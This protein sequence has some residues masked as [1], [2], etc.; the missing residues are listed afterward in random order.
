MNNEKTRAG[1]KK[2]AGIIL[3]VFT[4]AL[5]AAGAVIILRYTINKAFLMDYSMERY[6]ET[7]ESLLIYVETGENYVAPYNV[8]NVKY[9]N[10]DYENAAQYFY[11]AL[12]KEHPEEKDCLIRINL[13]LS[14][15]R[16][17]PFETMDRQD[18]DEVAE[19][20]DVLRT[21]RQ[22]LTENGCADEASD[23]FNG[24]SKDAEKLKRDID[25][26]IRELMKQP[27]SSENCPD[28]SEGQSNEGTRSNDQSDDPQNNESGGDIRE[29]PADVEEEQQRSLE[30]QLKEQKKDLNEE[31]YNSEQSQ[32]KYIEGSGEMSGYGEGAPW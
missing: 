29:E 17:Y 1:L 3:K 24:H 32:F 16:S 7:P 10:G 5:I 9:L 4:Y 12:G 20:L 21:A 31:N 14:L 25:D 18:P 30:Q 19:A 27:S 15:L 8:G 28:P 26:M 13:A 6:S 2:T 22:F 23:S 11:Y